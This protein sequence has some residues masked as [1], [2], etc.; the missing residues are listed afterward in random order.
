MSSKSPQAAVGL[1]RGKGGKGLAF[2]GGA[3]RHRKLSRDNIKG[4]TVPAMKRLARRGGVKR[5]SRSSYEQIR[6]R[7]KEFLGK[8][9]G[10]AVTISEYSKRKTVTTKDVV[11]A[12]KK[13]NRPLYGFD[14]N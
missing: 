6:E 2:G 11:F 4:I 14:N 12:L 10:N 13:L 7:L 1:G 3:K 9:V 8:V 5:I